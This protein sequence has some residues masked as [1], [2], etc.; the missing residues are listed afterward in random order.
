M[1]HVI[2]CLRLFS[3]VCVG[4]KCLHD[5]FNWLDCFCE[6]LCSGVFTDQGSPIESLTL[7]TVPHSGSLWCTMWAELH[8]WYT[9]VNSD[10]CV[11]L[12]QGLVPVNQVTFDSWPRLCVDLDLLTSF[13]N[14]YCHCHRHTSHYYIIIHRML[15]FNTF[16]WYEECVCVVW[17]THQVQTEHLSSE[18]LRWF[19]KYLNMS[20]LV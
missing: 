1:K 12:Y 20:D 5:R 6:V 9:P 4:G 8:H 13:S 11:M 19:G 2:L 10:L 14:I 3:P 16:E 18:T 7:S 17:T 15:H